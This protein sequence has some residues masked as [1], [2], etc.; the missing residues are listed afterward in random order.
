ML[1]G[2]PA[3]LLGAGL[4]ITTTGTESFVQPAFVARQTYEPA[5]K[6]RT[7]M[8]ADVE[9]ATPSRSHVPVAGEPVRVVGPNQWQ[10]VNGPWTAIDGEGK[11]LTVTTAG[12]DV[13]LQPLASATVTV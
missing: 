8:M 7:E 13:A 1:P 6:S 9:T 3:E 2:P 11:V 12:A 4:T 10:N 5:P